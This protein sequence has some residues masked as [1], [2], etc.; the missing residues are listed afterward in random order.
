MSRYLPIV[1]GVLLIVG[2]TIPQ[3][4]MT[5]RFSGENI[6]VE[7]QAE[8]LKLV[9]TKFGNWRGEEM[10]VDEQVRERAGAVGAVSRVYRNIRTRDVVNLWLI[11]G[12]GR[13]VSRHTP[14]VCYRTSGFEARAEEDSL[15]PMTFGDEEQAQFWTNTFFKEDFSGR[16][17]IR[18][19]WSWYNTESDE[20]PGEVVWEAPTN[21]RWYFGNTRALYKMYFTSEMRD[22]METAEQSPCLQF[23]REFLPEVNKAL[24]SVNL[25]DGLAEEPADEQSAT[26]AEPQPTDEP[27]ETAAQAPDKPTTTRDRSADDS[28]ELSFDLAPEGSSASAP[29]GEP[30]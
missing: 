3:I 10:D 30:K 2:L 20:H 1:L 6:T 23:A 5:D 14:N 17:L 27:Q 11:V 7:Q 12:H 9:P 25:G 18:V 21:P 28:P 24:S 19:F 16:Q 4:R 26:P 13:P 22:P 15:Y 8:L 29:I